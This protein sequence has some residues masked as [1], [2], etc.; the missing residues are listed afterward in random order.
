[1]LPTAML[2][3]TSVSDLFENR[4]PKNGMRNGYRRAQKQVFVQTLNIPC[5]HFFFSYSGER[6]RNFL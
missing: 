3:A 5:L 1:M 4:N 6:P 2:R